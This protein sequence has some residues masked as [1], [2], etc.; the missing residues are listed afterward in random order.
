LLFLVSLPKGLIRFLAEAMTEL[1][2][3]A[4]G[5]RV[6]Q[7]PLKVTI[8][9]VPPPEASPLSMYVLDLCPS[10]CSNSVETDSIPVQSDETLP[11]S[12][13]VS[14]FFPFSRTLAGFLAPSGLPLLSFLSPFCLR[15]CVFEE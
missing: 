15:R 4:V 12:D 7:G 9:G 3:I 6:P 14:D 1:Q 13:H 11:P 8:F 5:G 10:I 2:A